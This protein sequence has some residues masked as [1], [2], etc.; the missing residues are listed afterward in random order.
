MLSISSRAPLINPIHTSHVTFVTPA[1]RQDDVHIFILGR[2]A[3]WNGNEMISRTD[4]MDPPY[5][6]Y[7]SFDPEII[8]GWK[9]MPEPGTVHPSEL[10]WKKTTYKH[11]YALNAEHL[12]SGVRKL[13]YHLNGLAVTKALEDKPPGYVAKRSWANI[14]AAPEPDYYLV[15]RLKPGETRCL[16]PYMSLRW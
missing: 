11:G 5:V 12:H 10:T 7:V 1:E 9:G 2:Y 4:Y 14:V 13:W 3:E 16:P 6:K 8:T 15:E